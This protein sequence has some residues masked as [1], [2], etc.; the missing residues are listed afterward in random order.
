MSA[1]N[2]IRALECGD[3]EEVKRC[4]LAGALEDDPEI[5]PIKVAFTK[6]VNKLQLLTWAGI[7]VNVVLEGNT[8]LHDAITENDIRCVKVLL[9]AGADLNITDNDG[10]CALNAAVYEADADNNLTSD[11]IAMLLTYGASPNALLLDNS[12]SLHIAV[13]N[14]RPD[15]IR[16]LYENGSNLECKDNEGETPLHNA[17]KK[18]HYK[19]VQELVEA[20]ACTEGHEDNKIVKI[21]MQEARIAELE[22][23]VLELQ[24]RPGGPVFEECRHEFYRIANFQ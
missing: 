20:G 2:M 1:E 5:E 9:D 21:Y 11:I 14:N 6:K 19:C 24:L 7:N 16:L 3:I 13:S 17:I 15:I 18:G 23:Q 12:N 10:Y 8:P 4:I 22:A